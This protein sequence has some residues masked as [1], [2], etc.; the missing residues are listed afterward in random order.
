MVPRVLIVEDS[1][2]TAELARLA[3]RR[4][5]CEVAVASSAPRALELLRGELCPQVMVVDAQL[6]GI[7]PTFLMTLGD[8]APGACLILL[9]DRGVATPLAPRLAAR[10]VKPLQPRRLRAVVGELI[11][12]PDAGC[13]EP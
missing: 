10:L 1:P 6:P 11:G 4:L 2:S 7:P 3:L 13:G 12:C 5:T 9:I 8:E